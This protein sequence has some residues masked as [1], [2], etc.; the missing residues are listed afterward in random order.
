MRYRILCPDNHFCD[1]IAKESISKIWCIS[2]EG[3]C[4][5]HLIHCSV[6]LFND[7]RCD[8]LGYVA[9]SKTDDFRVRICL[10]VSCNFLQWWKTDSFPAISDNC[11]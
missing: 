10:G 7:R 9:D 2:V 1:G 5:S 3:L 4:V 11:H 8:R 6:Q